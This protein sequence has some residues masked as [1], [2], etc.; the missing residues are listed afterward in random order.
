MKTAMTEVD[1]HLRTRL[2]VIIWKQWKVP[3]KRQWGLQKLGIGKGLARL[4][5]YCGDRYQWVV[6]KTCVVRTGAGKRRVRKAAG[7]TEGKGAN[8]DFPGMAFNKGGFPNLRRNEA[9][10]CGRTGQCDRVGSFRV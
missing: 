7:R 6:T 1:E 8:G 5:S 10:P 4:T 3:G 2:R 9:A